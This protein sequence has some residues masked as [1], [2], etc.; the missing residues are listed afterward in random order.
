PSLR[1]A[2]IHR[3][4]GHV[5]FRDLRG[6][7][8]RIRRSSDPA[9]V[10]LL[11]SRRVCYPVGMIPHLVLGIET[12]CDDTAAAVVRDGREAISSVIASQDV[13][14]DF[15]GVVPELA[16]RAHLDLLSGTVRGAL[17]QAR[18]RLDEVDAVA[19]TRGPGLLGSLLVGVAYAK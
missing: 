19:V 5:G 14:R 3:G 8:G 6:V 9:R 10:D 2:G 12:S 11:G 13:H 4:P 15:G 16:S 1:I 7:G 17:E 18:V